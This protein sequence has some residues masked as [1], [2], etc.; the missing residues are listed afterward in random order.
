MDVIAGESVNL[1]CRS[2]LG[3]GLRYC[4]FMH[5]SG[6]SLN[7]GSHAHTTSSGVSYVG[8]GLE[9]GMSGEWKRQ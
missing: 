6:R 2:V 5:P 7:V 4:R 3:Y 8:N 9:A 1:S